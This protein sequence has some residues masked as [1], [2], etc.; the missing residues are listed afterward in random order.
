M[1]A[2]PHRPRL[3][4][5]HLATPTNVIVHHGRLDPGLHLLSKPYRRADLDRAVALA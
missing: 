5:L 2:L 3:K 1:A 4:I